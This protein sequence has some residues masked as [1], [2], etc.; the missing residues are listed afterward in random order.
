MSW[1]NARTRLNLRFTFAP[2]IRVMRPHFNTLS[3]ENWLRDFFGSQAVTHGQVV[4]RKRRDIERF[5]GM[6]RFLEELDTR[7]FQAVENREQ[8][9]V[10]CNNAPIRRLR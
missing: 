2:H 5:V 4:R 1:P 3:P 8:I 7:G 6:E 10:F 9:I